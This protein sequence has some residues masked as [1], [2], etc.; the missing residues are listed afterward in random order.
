MQVISGTPY[1]PLSLS[2][3]ILV[4]KPESQGLSNAECGPE[5]NNQ[6]LIYATE[7]FTVHTYLI[8]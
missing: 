6:T 2:G 7:E 4:A 8:L 1:D 3:M 5:T